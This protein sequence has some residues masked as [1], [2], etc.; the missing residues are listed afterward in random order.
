MH[1]EDGYPGSVGLFQRRI[2]VDS[3]LSSI[4]TDRLLREYLKHA[5]APALLNA[6]SQ[7]AEFSSKE[8]PLIVDPE[9]VMRLTDG[10]V[11]LVNIAAE[12]KRRGVSPP[13][14]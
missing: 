14:P 13:H 10:A 6:M 7:G 4:P 2:R 11:L 5:D 3:N 1:T 9:A 12:L 8:N